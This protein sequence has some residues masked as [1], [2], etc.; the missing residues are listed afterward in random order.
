MVRVALCGVCLDECD[1][2]GPH[3]L[4][5]RSVERPDPHHVAVRFHRGQNDLPPSADAR[6]PNLLGTSQQEQRPRI[7]G[8]AAPARAFRLAQ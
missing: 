1:G 7:P 8:S 4:G 6:L 3:E 2:A 5:K